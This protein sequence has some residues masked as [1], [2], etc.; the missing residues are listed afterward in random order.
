MGK[1]YV[2][3]T[4]IGNLGDISP[5]A[6]ETLNNVDKIAAEDTRR[7]LKLLNHF[8]IK[9]PVISNYKYNE[10]ERGRELI[11]Q[12]LAEDIDIAVVSDA[13]TPLISDPGAVI[14]EMARKNSIEVIAIPGASAVIS[15]LSVSGFIFTEFC[16]LGFIPRNKKEI[17][18]YCERIK[19][20]SIN[21]MVMFESPNRII[22]SL[23][24]IKQ[25]LPDVSLMVINDI[26][27]YY[28]RVYWGDISTVISQLE[29]SEKSTLGEYTIVMQKPSEEVVGDTD[30][31]PDT[32]SS[33]T[34][35]AL[36]VE[37]MVNTSCTLKDAVET[38]A[39]KTGRN[40][41]EIYKASLALKNL[42]S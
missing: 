33:M 19:K 37:E 22:K 35:E 1:I 8:E 14:V 38:V 5:R 12:I 13:G 26:T 25:T 39:G 4:P 31:E 42:F 2:V 27:K 11:E 34:A 28:E 40:K 23:K 7:T 6:L 29:E 9:T 24:E 36:L 21:V 17:Q 18:E 16:F 32:V 41:K 3:A 20:L 30:T 10:W 15:A